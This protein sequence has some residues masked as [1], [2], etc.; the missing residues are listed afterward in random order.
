MLLVMDVGNTETTAGLFENEI[1]VK[2]WGISTSLKR[3]QDEWAALIKIFFDM[4]RFDLSKLSGVAISSVVPPVDAILKSAFENILSLEPLFIAPGIKTGIQVLYENPIEVGA[5]RVVNAVSVSKL[6]AIPAIVIDFGTATT[7]DVVTSEGNYLGGVIAPGLM[8]SA[9]ALFARAARLP[10]VEIVKPKK[11][12]GRSTVAS[13]QSGLFY[14]YVSMV[15]GIVQKIKAESGEIN[16]VVATGGLAKLIS[17]EC[18][19]I[20][21]VDEDLTLKGLYLIYE[22]NRF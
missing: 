6:Y 20:N 21:N 1:L 4:A 5:D 19:F 2:R 8:I 22:K 10:K 17:P 18:P 7:F 16:S 12:I 13:M 15:E 3:T 14:G 9:E 11:V